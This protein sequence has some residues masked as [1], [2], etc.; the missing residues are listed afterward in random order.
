MSPGAGPLTAGGKGSARPK[1]EKMLNFK[2]SAP[3]LPVVLASLVVWVSFAWGL[4]AEALESPGWS[5][6]SEDVPAA[7]AEVG[8]AIASAD[9]SAEPRKFGA[10]LYAGAGFG[11]AGFA[12][13]GGVNIKSGKLSATLCA[14]AD[15]VFT[16]GTTNRNTDV[17]FLFGY[18]PFPNLGLAG[19]VAWVKKGRF[20]ETG[21][22][23]GYWEYSYMAGIPVE[24]RYAPVKSRLVGLGI[25][26]HVNFNED[27]IFGSITAGIELGKL[28]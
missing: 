14:T 20:Y 28:K 11:A 23:R 21:W 22:F 26:G 18:Y 8:A 24:V 17:G 10:W 6:P 7:A 25:V 3:K 4:P 1:E 13:N 5:L 15:G 12:G 27:E 19:G 9:P 2:R 16:W